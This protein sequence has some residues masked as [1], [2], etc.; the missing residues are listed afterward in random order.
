MDKEQ[1]EVSNNKS[2]N[3]KIDW[4]ELVKASIPILVPTIIAIA[5]LFFQHQYNTSQLELQKRKDSIQLILQQRNDS[6]QRRI[7]NIN[8]DLAQS[9][10][11]KDFLPL[12]KSENA[13]E[14]NIAYEA[15][16]YAVPI[17]GKRIQD[18]R[19]KYGNEE[20][21]LNSQEAVNIKRNDLV[22]KLFS[23]DKSERLLADNE[24]S[25]NWSNDLLIIDR[26]INKTVNCFEFKEEGSNC[27]QGSHNAFV[28]LTYFSRDKLLNY[29]TEIRDLVKKIPEQQRPTITVGNI[30]LDKL[31]ESKD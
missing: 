22:N 8:A 2:N 30:I 16:L 1:F 20:D 24:I 14:R 15:I 13:L 17:P 23:F 5:T 10:L 11:I 21:R 6:N 28:V 3:Q 26:L 19:I 9:A 29:Q 27:N 18:L 4:V 7:A 31:S 12:I 25:L